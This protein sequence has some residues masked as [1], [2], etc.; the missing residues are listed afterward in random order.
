MQ[1][2]SSNPN[3]VYQQN[4]FFA[5]CSHLSLFTLAIRFVRNTPFDQNAIKPS[6][7]R[8]ELNF[9]FFIWKLFELRVLNVHM[10]CT[11]I[12]KFGS[13]VFCSFLLHYGEHVKFLSV[14]VFIMRNKITAT[15]PTI[16]TGSLAVLNQQSF[17][18]YYYRNL[19]LVFSPFVQAL[20]A[21]LLN[22]LENVDISL[23]QQC[24]SRDVL[25]HKCYDS[26][27]G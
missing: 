2:S 24:W 12:F 8:F 23:V 4:I 17:K 20:F 13:N 15:L 11:C 26:V 6:S 25:Q 9:V 19:K 1:D 10:L 3:E 14:F 5:V 21:S 16:I 27:V 7:K 18:C 22:F